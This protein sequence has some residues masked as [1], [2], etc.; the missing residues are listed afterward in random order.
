MAE[1]KTEIE[2]L[3]KATNSISDQEVLM[4][5]ALAD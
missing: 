2:K 4:M 3:K 5:D 1:Q